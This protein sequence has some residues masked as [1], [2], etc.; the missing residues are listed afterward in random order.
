MLGGMTVTTG[1][2]LVI[3]GSAFAATGSLCTANGKNLCVNSPNFND[4]TSLTTGG[5]ARTIDFTGVPGGNGKLELTGGTNACITA[6]SANSYV[7]KI[8]SCSSTG[9]DWTFFDNG[10]GTRSFENVHYSG[11]Y[12]ASD[13]SSGDVL[14]AQPKGGNGWYYKW[15]P[16]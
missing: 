11:R 8:E 2:A 12:L 5:G 15:R 14:T 3:S 9:V 10:D 1:I 16:L 4:G 6:Y 13:N 7:V